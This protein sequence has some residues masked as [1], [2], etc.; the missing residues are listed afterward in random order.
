ME[1]VFK[2][3]F[4]PL[5]KNFSLIDS[6]WVRGFFI[7]PLGLFG[8]MHFIKPHFF[9]F[10]VPT[11]AGNP[12]MW[13]LFSGFCLTLAA[14]SIF[15][16]ILAKI[17]SFLLI[18]FVLTFIVSVDIPLTFGHTIVPSEFFVISWLKDTSL[19]GGSLFYYFI[20]RM[21]G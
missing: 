12:E 14:V 6:Y 4:S 15:T 5:P 1:Y 10:M 2:L 17:S 21:R 3:L 19:L 18:I 8:I 16:K 7:L 9:E 13:V 20:S 11:Y